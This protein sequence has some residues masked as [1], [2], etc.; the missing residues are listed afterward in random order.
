MP[1]DEEASGQMLA[2]GLSF[3]TKRTTPPSQWCQDQDQAVKAD[4]NSQAD[5]EGGGIGTI[6]DAANI[7]GPEPR[8][9]VPS[10]LPMFRDLQPQ[11]SSVGQSSEEPCAQQGENDDAWMQEMQRWT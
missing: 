4:V 8:H 2:N 6:G 7:V 3:G 9:S 5:K 1:S 11:L 10:F